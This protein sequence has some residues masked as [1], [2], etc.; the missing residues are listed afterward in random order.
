MTINESI[1]GVGWLIYD[2]SF[3]HHEYVDLFSMYLIKSHGWQT[4]WFWGGD[5]LAGGGYDIFYGN[6]FL[7][8][9]YIEERNWG[10]RWKKNTKIWKGENNSYYS[11]PKIKLIFV[12]KQPLSPEKQIHPLI[13]V[14]WS[15]TKYAISL[16]H[17]KLLL[18]TSSRNNLINCYLSSP[19]AVKQRESRGRIFDCY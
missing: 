19:I 13:N 12:E 4:G 5:F 17:A 2:I 3:V 16:M 11:C 10:E 7:F 9:N 15:V 14:K 6:N 18:C 1:F 8:P